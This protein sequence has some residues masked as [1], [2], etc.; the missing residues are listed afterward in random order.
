MEIQWLEGTRPR[1]TRTDKEV[2]VYTEHKG[3]HDYTSIVFYSNAVRK[4]TDGNSVSVGLAGSRIYFK[5][6]G[7]SRLCK[8]PAKNSVIVRLPGERSQY[9]GKYSLMFDAEEKKWFIGA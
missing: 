4:I 3:G 1:R 2:K 5:S 7:A 6:G 8:Y 9:N